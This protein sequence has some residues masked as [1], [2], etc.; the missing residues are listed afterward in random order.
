MG[1]GHHCLVNSRDQ[2][3][4]MGDGCNSHVHQVPHFQRYEMAPM[5]LVLPKDLLVLCY[6]LATQ[7]AGL[8]TEPHPDVMPIPGQDISWQPIVSALG[9]HCVSTCL[10]DP[11]I[12]SLLMQVLDLSPIAHLPFFHFRR[13]FLLSSDL[14]CP[15]ISHFLLPPLSFLTANPARFLL[16]I[17]LFESASSD[18][19]VLGR[20]QILLQAC[21]LGSLRFWPV[22]EPVSPQ[23]FQRMHVVVIHLAVV[24]VALLPLCRLCA[25]LH[26]VLVLLLLLL[27]LL[28]ARG[29]NWP[30]SCWGIEQWLI[31][32]LLTLL[33]NGH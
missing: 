11:T 9:G 13:I 4:G 26:I 28:C 15:P 30:C 12:D 22:L 1:I 31:F 6:R 29:I 17:H 25:W 32:L 16:H 19:R 18:N 5:H 20:Q 24:C 14:S 2:S 27:L 7:C 8:S 10:N 23:L 33:R 3:F 21:C